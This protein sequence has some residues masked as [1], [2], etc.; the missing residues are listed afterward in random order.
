MKQPVIEHNPNEQ[1]QPWW[2]WWV[3]WAFVG[4]LWAGTLIAGNVVWHQVLLGVGTGVLLVSWVA[5]IAGLDTPASW[6]RKPV[7]NR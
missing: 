2:L 3:A 4:V 5:D 7:R 1:R 6:R